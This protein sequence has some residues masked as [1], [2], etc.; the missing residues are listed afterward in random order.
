[1]GY[2]KGKAKAKAKA[3]NLSSSLSFSL[4]SYRTV[5]RQEKGQTRG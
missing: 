1:M 3:V 4:E 2:S 5:K